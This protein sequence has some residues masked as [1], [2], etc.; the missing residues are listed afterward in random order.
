MIGVMAKVKNA[1]ALNSLENPVLLS[2]RRER[3]KQEVRSRILEAANELFPIDGFQETRVDDI[4]ERADVAHKTF[5]N[6]F[7]TIWIRQDFE[8]LGFQ[9]FKWC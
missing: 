4:C 5:F 3:R 9:I 8:T 7:S 2:S 6:H 1:K